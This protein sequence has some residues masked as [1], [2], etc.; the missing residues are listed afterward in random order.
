MKVIWIITGNGRTIPLNI[1]PKISY[2]KKFIPWGWTIG[3]GVYVDDVK[4]EVN[5]VKRKFNIIAIII[6]FFV[7]CL[8]II[9]LLQHNSEEIK[10]ISAEKALQ[11]S[12]EKFRSIVEQSAEGILLCNEEGKIIEWNKAPKK[13]PD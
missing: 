13:I 10:R 3:T 8:L 9:I 7:S 5:K 12:E 4:V 1:T 6:M 11:D 2:V